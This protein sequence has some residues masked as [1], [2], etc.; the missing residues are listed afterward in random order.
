MRRSCTSRCRSRSSRARTHQPSIRRSDRSARH[1]NRHSACDRNRTCRRPP[2]E[3]EPERWAPRPVRHPRWACQTCR[4]ASSR[5]RRQRARRTRRTRGEARQ[6]RSEGSSWRMGVP[7]RGRVQPAEVARRE[8]DFASARSGT[9]IA[10]RER[11]GHISSILVPG[12]S[13]ARHTRNGDVARRGGRARDDRALCHG[14]TPEIVPSA[15]MLTFAFERHDSET[16]R[17]FSS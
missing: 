5:S 9:T 8:D 17:G 10:G 6:R 3:P 2:P 7:Q 13:S 1:T 16:E 4:A 14:T 15:S 11:M 12:G